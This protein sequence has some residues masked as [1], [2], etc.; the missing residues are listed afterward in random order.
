MF[1]TKHR[2]ATLVGLTL[3]VVAHGADTKS[4]HAAARHPE[5]MNMAPQ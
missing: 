1:F 5:T 3:G 4:R 2:L